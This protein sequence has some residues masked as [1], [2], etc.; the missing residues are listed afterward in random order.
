MT[1]AKA[2]NTYR[3]GHWTDS[4]ARTGCTVI[5]FPAPTPTIVDV[6]GG[7]PG[8]RETDLLQEGRMVRHA[9]AI[10]LT[11][12]SAFGLAAAD[13]V[14]RGLR[15]QGRGFA[16]AAGP[17]PIVPAAVLFDLATGAPA[18][19]DA[20]AGLAALRA[21]VVPDLAEYGPVGAGTGATVGSITGRPTPG[22]VGIARHP[23]PGGAVT[24]IMAV[25]AFG[26]VAGDDVRETALARLI[27]LD[28]R[29]G[30]NT[31][32]GVVVVDA[33]ADFSALRR[34][35]IA[36]HDG[37]A[38]MIVPAHTIFDGDAIFVSGPRAGTPA[39]LDVV[40]LAMATE[41]AVEAA[42]RAGVGHSETVSGHIS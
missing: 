9:D 5:V 14:M 36:A 34:C 20:E 35:A 27:E 21:A 31:T 30:E 2:P 8:T 38:R 37:L 10:L 28:A 39:P 22:G 23:I 4:D 7:A 18:W 15:E 16:T 24:A 33:P 17:V 25:N 11:G 19:P 3:V 32:I 12:G 41:F 29:Q 13:G 40:G 26:I 42:I 6:R 1:T